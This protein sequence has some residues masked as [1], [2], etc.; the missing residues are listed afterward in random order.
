MKETQT[1]HN[2]APLKHF[3]AGLRRSP[4]NFIWTARPKYV[5]KGICVEISSRRIVSR[6]EEEEFAKAETL[7]TAQISRDSRG[8]ITDISLISI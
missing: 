3:D 2:V 1:C 6:R 7:V 8:D 5:C 4:G